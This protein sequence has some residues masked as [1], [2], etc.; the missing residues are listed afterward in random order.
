MVNPHPPYPDQVDQDQLRARATELAKTLE[1]HPPRLKFSRL[2]KPWFP[3][4]MWVRVLLARPYIVIAPAFATLSEAEQEAELARAVVTADL[5]KSTLLKYA[6]AVICLIALSVAVIT[7]PLAAIIATLGLPNP[8]GFT[9]TEFLAVL[10]A[11]GY[12]LVAQIAWDRRIVY[13]TDR[14]VAESLGHPFLI[15]T[16]HLSRRLRYKRRGLIGMYLSLC[17]P[18]ESKRADALADLAPA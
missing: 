15:T 14:R 1:A 16:H 5:L 8:L 7:L 9:L 12:A 11:L 4:G 2:P 18:D 6:A 17:T 10:P 3:G 13:R